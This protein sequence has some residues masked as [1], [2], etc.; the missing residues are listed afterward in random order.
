M[1]ACPAAEARHVSDETFRHAGETIF[2]SQRSPPETNPRLE[3]P[4]NAGRQAACQPHQHIL[5][6]RGS[7]V[8]G[9]EDLRVIRIEREPGLALLFLAQTVKPFD[10]RMAV[11]A[12]LPFAGGTPLELRGL[13]RIA[14]SL[15][16]ANQSLDVDAIVN[17][18]VINSHLMPESILRV[19]VISLSQMEKPRKRNVPMRP[20]PAGQEEQLHCLRTPEEKNFPD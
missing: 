3:P 16:R 4:S 9:S 14:Q 19:S 8:R 17:R 7:L 12:V 20:H 15:T 13:R 2:Q 1:M 10:G 6:G 11:R 5:D 18:T